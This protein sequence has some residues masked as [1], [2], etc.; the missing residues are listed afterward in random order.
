VRNIEELGCPA[1]KLR[2]MKRSIFEKNCVFD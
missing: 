1:A 2:V